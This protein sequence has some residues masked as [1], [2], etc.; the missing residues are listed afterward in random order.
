MSGFLS[1]AISGLQASQVALR[2]AGNNIS[3][4][5]TD[6]YSRQNVNFSTRPEQQFGDAGFLGNGVNTESVTRV[7]ND[8]VNTQLRL[9]TATFNQLDTFNSNIGKVDKLFSDVNTGLVGGLQDFFSALQNGASDPA[10]SPA[11]QLVITQADSLSVRYN[12]LYDRLVETE[13]GVDGEIKTVVAQI[14]ALAKTIANLNQSLATKNASGSGA[15]PNALLDQRDE[16]LRKLAE[17]TSVQLVKEDGGDIN[18][19]IGNGEPLVVGP[20]V[21]KFDV[22]TGGKISLVSNG[23]SS[24]VTDQVSGGKLGGLLSFKDT[25]LEPS[26]NELGRVA[27]VMSDT[28]NKVQTQGLDLNGNFGSAMF[29]DINEK[30]L[31]Y[32]RVQHG[33]N[34]PPNDRLISLDIADSSAITISDY[35]FTVA[36]NTNNYTIKRLSDNTIV[37]QGLLS[38][39]YPSSIEFDGLKLNL[40][41]G[42]FQGGDS[43]ILQ[44]TRTGARDVHS[45]LTAPENLAFASPIRTGSASGNTG[46][47]SISAGQVLGLVDANNYPLAAFA[48]PGKLSPPLVIHFTSDTTYEVLDNTDPAHP[49]PLNPA[50]RE[51]TFIPNRE[52][53]I[54]TNDINETRIVG[55]GSRLGLPAGRTAIPSALFPSLVYPDTPF[56]KYGQQNGYPAEQYT[57]SRTDPRTGLTS[58]QTM[59]T[60]PNASAAE[61]AARISTVAGV[62]AHAFTTAT[63][64]DINIDPTGFAAPLQISVNGENLL[65]YIGGGLSPDVPNPNVSEVDFN[66]YLAK[67]INANANLKTLGIRAESS[68]NPVTGAPELHLVAASGVNLDIRLTAA[69][70][71]GNINNISVNDGTNPNVRLNGQDVGGGE[72]SAVTVGG[73][74]DITM[75]DGIKLASIPQVS[76]ILGDTTAANFAQSSYIGYQV[77]VSGQPKAGDVFTVGFNANSKN[78][79]RNALA[80][81]AL[82]TT[83]TMQDGTMSFG[84]GYGRLVE[85]VGTKSNLSRINTDASKSLMEQTKTMRDGVSGVN[86]DEEAANLIQFQQLYTANARVITVAKDLFDTLVRSLG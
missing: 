76:A 83:G 9:D 66:N 78:D 62:S 68:S 48:T 7:V 72:Q 60:S 71:A 40:E 73:K 46:K 52:N 13:K 1:N 22:Q 74:I 26:L 25:V 12:T 77:S 79:N 69:N 59:V 50:M 41:S 58:S 23:H 24:D 20:N 19:F 64:T 82:E 32:A 2:T 44:P 38:G 4:A 65:G 3:N 8:F 54:F 86:L 39:S 49:K 47:G 56:I 29:T 42:S 63:I 85:E 70:T 21:S 51:Q 27:I 10:S 15:E 5:N 14:G 36:P 67:Q 28:F 57:F 30:E 43:F 35:S 16:A 53:N 17:L 81:T 31:T 6:G 61:T 18:V 45:L 55:N 84:Q 75:S 37:N 33:N 34:A 11:R 80:M